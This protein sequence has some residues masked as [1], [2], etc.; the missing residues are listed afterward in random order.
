MN[1]CRIRALLTLFYACYKSHLSVLSYMTNVHPNKLSLGGVFRFEQVIGRRYQQYIQKLDAT[2]HPLSDLPQLQPCGNFDAMLEFVYKRTILKVEPTH[3]I[4]CKKDCDAFLI[5][6]PNY[7]I[8]YIHFFV[9][10]L[11]V[12]MIL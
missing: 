1:K 11:P 8:F 9:L 2:I 5:I 4:T 3:C 10:F 7:F 6:I 12:Q